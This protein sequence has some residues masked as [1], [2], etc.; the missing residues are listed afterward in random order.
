MSHIA[1][2][3]A[4]SSLTEPEKYPYG[5]KKNYR[6]RPLCHTLPLFLEFIFNRTL[7]TISMQIISILKALTIVVPV[8][9]NL[10]LD[11]LAVLHLDN[12][13]CIMNLKQHSL[14]KVFRICISKMFWIPIFLKRILY[15]AVIPKNDSE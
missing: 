11:A 5:S 8:R 4:S 12:R 6:Y 15:T 9:E 10:I 1:K 14:K 13:L 2:A 3:Q 7:W